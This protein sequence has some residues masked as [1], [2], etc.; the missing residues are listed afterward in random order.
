MSLSVVVLVLVLLSTLVTTQ[1]N[2]IITI[3]IIITGLSFVLGRP[4]I[5]PSGS[6]IV[7][8]GNDLL[9]K[10]EG[11]G[12]VLSYQW[13]DINGAVISTSNSSPLLLNLTKVT[14]SD[15]G[16]YICKV[17]Y[18]NSATENSSILITVEGR[19]TWL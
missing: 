8:H 9:A 3:I 7:L 2:T 4:V 1:G 15:S 19:Y 14:Q 16:T 13:L 6:V 18:T 12:N 10:C 17:I 11:S 5:T